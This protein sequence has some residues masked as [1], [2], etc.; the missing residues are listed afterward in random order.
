MTTYAASLQMQYGDLARWWVSLGLGNFKLR[1]KGFADVGSRASNI[2]SSQACRPLASLNF[3]P[4]F[5]GSVVFRRQTAPRV[6]QGPRAEV[7]SLLFRA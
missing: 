7:H 4:T 1:V 3:E 2:L 5:G 6:C